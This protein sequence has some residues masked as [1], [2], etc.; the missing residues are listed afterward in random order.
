MRIT[1]L[2]VSRE[3][4]AS[5]DAVYA[6]IADVT[7]M[8]EW[9]TECHTC[10][11]ID[12]ATEAAVGAQFLGSNANNGAEWEITNT[13]TAADP[14]SRFAFDCSVPTFTFASWAYDIEA[15]D[16][17]C[18][19]TESWKDHRTDEMANRP[20]ISGVAD[21]AEYNRQSMET[22]LERIAAAVES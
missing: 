1:E 20:S 9:S 8:G 10:E 14:G 21:R 12:G 13:V 22:T 7:R 5:P 18:R 11:W 6:A 15:T 16:Q 3:I 19:V 2:E 17:G 4:A